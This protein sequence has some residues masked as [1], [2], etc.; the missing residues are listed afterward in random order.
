ML[1]VG[2]FNPEARREEKIRSRARDQSRLN[3]GQVSASYLAQQNCMVS[4]LDPSRAKIVRRRLSV[5]LS[6]CRQMGG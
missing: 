3:A 6:A 4:S 5:D 2:A 1:F